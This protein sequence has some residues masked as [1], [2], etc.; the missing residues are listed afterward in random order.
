MVH[1]SPASAKLALRAEMRARRRALAAEQPQAAE[2]AA[3]KPAAGRAAA[4]S[5][6]SP[7]IIR[8]GAEID[9]G[10]GAG[11]PAGRRARG[12]PCR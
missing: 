6:S 2:Q 7:A 11:R 12:S 3:R 5:R 10:R 9:P 1:A 4:A 8:H